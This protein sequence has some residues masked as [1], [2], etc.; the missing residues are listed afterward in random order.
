MI[1]GSKD[2]VGK[3]NGAREVSCSRSRWPKSACHGEQGRG[4]PV[5][6]LYL[7][8]RLPQNPQ[9]AR[10]QAAQTLWPQLGQGCSLRRRLSLRTAP[11]PPGEPSLARPY[12]RAQDGVGALLAVIGGAAP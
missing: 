2:T 8:A 9:E 11:L 6:D 3:A 5:P 7:W 10:V 1:A 12:L 4:S